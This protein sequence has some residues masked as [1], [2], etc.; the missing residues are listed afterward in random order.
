MFAPT[1]TA[2]FHGSGLVQGVLCR[3]SLHGAACAG[4]ARPGNSGVP[5]ALSSGRFAPCG[6]DARVPR[7]PFPGAFARGMPCEN[8]HSAHAS[9]WDQAALIFGQ[10]PG[11]IL[12]PAMPAASG[13][14]PGLPD[15]TPRN[16]ARVQLFEDQPR[17]VP[18][19]M[20]RVQKLRSGDEMKPL[21]LRPRCSRRSVYF[22]P[23]VLLEQPP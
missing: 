8:P 21:R 9:S 17:G 6:R 5:P 4:T 3:T 18:S 23:V 15:S 13:E 16:R 12:E 20:F 19:R 1:R 2:L 7:T 22:E 10:H 11:K 14:D